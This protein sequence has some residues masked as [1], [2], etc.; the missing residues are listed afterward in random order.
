MS[1][2]AVSLATFWRLR[3]EDRQIVATRIVCVFCWKK[4]G[5]AVGCTHLDVPKVHHNAD[6]AQDNEDD[7][8]CDGTGDHG[9]RRRARYAL[10]LVP[11][12]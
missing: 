3:K 7:H 1:T 10:R 5:T 12:N 8:D 4:A 6:A 11:N 2:L 9:A